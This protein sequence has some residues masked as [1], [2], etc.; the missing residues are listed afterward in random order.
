MGGD[1]VE[2]EQLQDTRLLLVSGFMVIEVE[3]VNRELVFER[4]LAPPEENRVLPALLQF[5]IGQEVEGSNHVEIFLCGLLQGGVEL[6]EHAFET[7]V[8]QLVLQALACRHDLFL[9]M[10]KAS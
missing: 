1:K 2:V 8:R 9:L 6:L 7:Q 4:G 10:T 3:L 5:D